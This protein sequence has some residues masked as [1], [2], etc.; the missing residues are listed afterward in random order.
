V[1]TF[2]DQTVDIWETFEGA[3]GATLAETDPDG[4]LTPANTDYFKNGAASLK[5]DADSYATG[6]AYL[7]CTFPSAV[8]NVSFGMWW[9]T[10]S[11]YGT[12]GG[13]PRPFVVRVHWAVVGA[14]MRILDRIDND[15]GSAREFHCVEGVGASAVG[16]GSIA[17]N[18]WYWV[19]GQYNRN[20]TSYW[21][22]Y[23]EG[24]VE[25]G[26]NSFTAA[27]YNADI[28]LLANITAHQAC[29]F[30]LDD[31][32]VDYTDATYPLLGWDVGGGSGGLLARILLE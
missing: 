5:V 13:D 25:V 14:Q 11:G 12:W 21:K 1:A 15:S 24:G 4:I 17:D 19:T 27:D 3:Y 26:E 23:T 28:I 20:A 30:Y 8:S 2:H 7:T 29:A 22:V 10:G 6:E 32:V 18:T 16:T 9:R 31:F